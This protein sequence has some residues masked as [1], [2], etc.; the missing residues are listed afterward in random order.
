MSLYSGAVGSANGKFVL[1]ATALADSMALAMDDAMADAYQKLKGSA[2]PDKAKD[3]RRMLFVAIA[4]GMLSYLQDHH[5]EIFAT[6][7][8]T[9]S[10]GNPID[11]Q[12]NSVS[13]NIVTDPPA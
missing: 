8:L 7:N 11:F 2:L 10:G 1:D 6:M 5:N 4:R 9:P 12:V 3:D 13:L